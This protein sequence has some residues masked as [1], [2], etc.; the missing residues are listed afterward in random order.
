[1]DQGPPDT[2]RPRLSTG[3]SWSVGGAHHGVSLLHPTPSPTAGQLPHHPPPSTQYQQHSPLSFARPPG[4]GDLPPP[5]PPP[6]HSHPHPH[7]HPHPHA[8]PHAHPHPPAAHTP[9]D[10]RRQHEPDRFPPMQEH[11]QPP[12]S[13]A[14]PPFPPYPPREPMIKADPADDA[15]PQVRRPLS[16]GGSVQDNMTPVTPHSAVPPPPHSQPYG[17]DRRH[18]SFD[19]GPPPPMYSRQQSYQPQTPLPHHQP[20]DY[21]TQYA[22]HGELPYPIQVATAAGKR[23]AQRASQAC[24]LCRQLKAKCDELKPCKSCKEKKMECKYR[25]AVPKQQDKIAADILDAILAM[26]SRFDSLDQRMSRLERR[27]GDL[28]VE[29]MHNDDERPESAESAPFTAEDAGSLSPREPAG[30]GQP[31]GSLEARN[32]TRNMEEE[33]EVEP[34]PTVPPGVP[35][36]PHNHT[37][38]AAFLL[39][40]RPISFLVRGF[41]EAENV[42]YVGEFPIRQEERRGLL[43]IWG[44]GEGLESS[45]RVDKADREAIRDAGTIE[46]VQDDVSD[47]G[48]PSP[49]DCW[50]G[51]SGSPAPIDGKPVIATQTPDFSEAMVWKYVKSYKDNIQNMH[52][53]IIPAEL[54]A[55]VR[56]FLDTIQQSL[57]RQSRGG[58][59]THGI[60]KFVVTPSSQSETGSKRKRSSPPPEGAE[61]T[62]TSAKPV[63]QRSINNALVLL[64]LALGKIC[65]HK[66]RI[67][68]VVAVSE[69]PQGS[70]MVRNGYP[71]SPI[72]GS[73]PSHASHSHSAGFPSPKEGVERQGPSRRSSFQGGGPSVKG[74]TSLKRNLDV[75]PGLDYF[76]YATDI[77]GGQIAGTSLRHIHAYLLAGLYHGQ[78]GRVMESYAYIK[79]A[80]F[81]LQIKMRPSL[82]RFRKLQETMPADQNAVTE[83]SD[84][85]LVFAFWTSLQLES[86][87]IAELPLPQSHILAYEDMMPYPNIHVARGLGFEEHVLQSYLA[88]LY[89]RKSLNQ[90]HGILYNPEIPLHGPSSAPGS[91]IIEYIQTSLDMRFVP[92]E[93]KFMRNDP[94]AG[95][96]LAARLRAKYWGAHVITYRPFVRQILEANFQKTSDESPM[97]ASDFRSGVVVPVIGPDKE[98]PPQMIEYAVKGVQALIES[99]RA[100]HGLKEKR[101]IITNVFG[102]AHAQWGN[103]L[104]LAA[105]FRDPTLSGFVHE[106]ILKE[107][108]FRTI[109]F[110]KIIAHPTSALHVDLRILEGIERELWGKPSNADMM[111]HPTGSS[112]SSS[113]SGGP[114]PHVPPMVPASA[115]PSMPPVARPPGIHS[116]VNHVGNGM[117]SMSPPM[118]SPL[119]A[120][121]PGPPAPGMLPPM[122]HQSPH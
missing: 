116:P 43:R 33:K 101:F 90:I 81:A 30:A 70:P 46:M 58:A 107:L 50:G 16:T 117:M 38:L 62:S 51:I 15:L 8:H 31:I 95:D 98:I 103:L 60:A 73:S 99:T 64:V 3:S 110:F 119:P 39:R 13:P 21:P 77:L 32:I 12:H 48:A 1:M 28:P 122:Q 7:P 29:P 79:E 9:I 91:N 4:H 19:N 35:S 11:R 10:D 85:Q 96:I 68:D 63:F 106:D 87:I 18:M 55:M 83:K 49:A 89:L 84:N 37:T 75:I 36:I 112:F 22:S 27:N 59:A 20:Y 105:V 88:Q 92:P 53:L 69:A 71:A 102:T 44:R 114:P 57:T 100:F 26:Q 120:T 82:D 86:D 97:P 25:E 67:P 78:L 47:A 74:G 76:A 111:D 80:G 42:K 94:P 23:K 5:P 40:W 109:S 93:F 121:I 66:D 65:L 118:A 24:D 52:P 104:T 54:N 17:E 2:K 6:Q 34:G 14:H 115:G 108:F 61:S 113:A 72:Q 56:V 41:L 45:L